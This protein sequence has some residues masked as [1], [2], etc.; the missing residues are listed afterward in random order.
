MNENKLLGLAWISPYIIGLI[1]FTAFPFVS[2]FFLSFTEYDLMSPPVFNGIENYRYMLTEDSLFWKS[3]GVTFAYVFL[4]IPLKLAFALGIAFVLNFKLRGIGFFRTAYYIPSILGSSVAIAVLWR[5]LFA[6]DGLLNSFLAVFGIDAINWLGEPS[7]A[8]MSVT[9]L[10][11][12][13]FGSAMVIFL[14]ALQN[15]PQS[16]YEAAMIDG[17]SKWQM[18]MKVTV[19][20]IT[21]V[22]F[23]NFIMQT[24]QAFQE[25]TGPYV[26]TGG[27]PTYYTYLFSLYIYD[28]AFKYFDMGYGAALAW[29]LFLVERSLRRSPLSHRNTGSS[30]PP[31][32]E[33]KMA[34]IQQMAPVMSDADREVAR[35]L[36]REKVSRVVRYVVLIFVGL[37][38]LYPLAWMFSASFKP[39]HEIFTTL[40]LWPAHATWD[41]FINGWK[42]GTEYHFGHYMLNTF[43]YVIPKVV[44][45]IISST[46]VAYGFA[47]FE[48]PWKKFWFATLIT[49]ML[50]PSTVLL[51]PQYLMF[52]EMG[53]LN[54]YLPLYLP[55]AFATQGF[56]VFMLIQFLRGVPRDMEEAAQIDGCNS[57]QV[58]WYVVVPILKPAIISVALF[59]FMWSM[60][61]FIGPL[62]YVYSVDKYPIALAL[63]MSIDVT[64]G[65]PWNEILAM[66]SISILPSIIVFFL[67]QRYFVQ[68]VTSSGIKG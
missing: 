20:L 60:N 67:A 53:M 44:L 6:I 14:A 64:E 36:R 1:V 68:G 54:S 21:P 18:F 50:L 38:M 2:S 27:G 15:V 5:A 29:V 61:D 52:R 25:F 57:I 13:Q 24:T 49:T 12:W 8:L 37:L 43:K 62:I 63:K 7:L 47:R 55:L 9:L 17:A 66:A 42:T 33:A 26:I 3:M 56:F 32:R 35:T 65:A 39:N 58:L 28:T 48:I 23:F 11:V 30:T 22:I 16:Q 19:P 45:T 31:I 59:Q 40:G 46:I 34:D 10:R 41:G 4:T 51:I